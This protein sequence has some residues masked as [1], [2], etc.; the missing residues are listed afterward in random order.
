MRH[1]LGSRLIFSERKLIIMAERDRREELAAFLH[2]W[3]DT[4]QKTKKAFIRL[5]EDL[6]RRPET[7]LAFKARPGV[8]YSLRAT[9]ALQQKRQLFVVVDAVEDPQNRW[10]SVCFYLD[11]ITDPEEKGELIPAG[12]LGED[13]YCFNLEE[14]DE[15]YLCYL[16]ARLDEAHSR[17]AKEVL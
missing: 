14:W 8:S 9:H 7:T 11:M 15:D 13:G 5:K 17:A 4:P 10:L 6:S 1:W 3:E 12:L 2:A 16:E